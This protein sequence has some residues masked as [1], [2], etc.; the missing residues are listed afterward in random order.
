MND[1]PQVGEFDDGH[2]EKYNCPILDEDR[3]ANELNN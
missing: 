3:V 1:L 2:A